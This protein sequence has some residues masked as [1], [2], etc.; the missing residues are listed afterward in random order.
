MKQIKKRFTQGLYR[1]RDGALLGVLKGIAD[2]FNLP[3][4]WLRIGVIVG[5]L[6][7]G[8][9]PVGAIYL[10][11][12]LI[13]KKEHE[14]RFKK[15]E[16]QYPKKLYRS[17]NGA[18]LGVVKGIADYFDCSLFWLRLLLLAVF[19][20]TGFIPGLALYGLSALLIAKEPVVPVNTMAEQEF[21]DSYSR[22]RQGAIHR[23]KR[24]YD[25]LE[26][27]LRR[28]ENIVTDREFDWK[29]KFHSS[30]S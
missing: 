30:P 17:R 24:R 10:L 25:G 9:F 29:Q 14:S 27:R 18:L 16:S 11:L 3:V 4:I 22:S 20:S 19:V 2:Y 15:P 1:A 5:F 28:M 23:V 8:F 13:M 26:N 7:T 12:A 6:V 21:Y